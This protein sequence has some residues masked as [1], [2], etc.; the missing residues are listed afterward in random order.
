[1]AKEKMSPELKDILLL[2]SNKKLVNIIQKQ[3]NKC[4]DFLIQ[5]K[6][7]Y[8]DKEEVE[9][10]LYDEYESIIMQKLTKSTRYSSGYIHAYKT[11]TEA[12]RELNKFTKKCKNSKLEADL[13]AMIND[14]VFTNYCNEFGT[15]YTAFDNKVVVTFQRWYNVVYKKLHPDLQVEYEDK[16]NKYYNILKRK[17][18]HLDRVY[19]MDLK[20]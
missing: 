15:Y 2:E 17:A 10:I 14:Y 19:G 16:M 20:F 7:E 12:V 8:L 5:L 11:M 3:A 4:T 1:M 18:D 6:M 9:E 13:L